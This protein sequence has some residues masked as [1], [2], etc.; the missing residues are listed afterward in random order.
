MR[1]GGEWRVPALVIGMVVLLAMV[2]VGVALVVHHNAAATPFATTEP[3]VAASPIV[4]SADDTGSTVAATPT[5]DP[6][7]PLDDAS[8]KNALDDEVTRDQSAAEQLVGS[9]VPQLSS[10]RPGLVVNGITYG[11]LQ[12]WQ[13]FE[14]SRAQYPNALLIWSGNYISFS[15]PDFYVTVVSAPYSDGQS[16]N[17]WCDD[18]NIDS[19]NCY[20]ELLSHT[21]GPNGT[22][23]LRN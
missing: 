3:S 15:Y 22:T 4:S 19:D 5:T 2:G 14:Q 23:M 11:Y 10:K 9:W 20:A 8:A 12:I 7:Q 18:A 1:S 13:D 6:G 21:V 17:Q 16:A